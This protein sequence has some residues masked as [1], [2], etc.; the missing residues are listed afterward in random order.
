[1]AWQSGRIS[2]QHALVTHRDGSFE[3]EPLSDR[4]ATR[5]NGEQTTGGK[6]EDGDEIGLGHTTFRF[7]TVW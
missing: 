7:R 6:L 4:N 3:I 5:V 1:M 2:R